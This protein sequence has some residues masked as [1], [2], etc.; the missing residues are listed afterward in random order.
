MLNSTNPL[1]SRIDLCF[2]FFSDSFSFNDVSDRDWITQ[3]NKINSF[4]INGER[5]GF[6]FGK[7]G[8]VCRVYDKT[9]EIKEQS[10]KVYL[11]DLWK[12]QGWNGESTVWRVE[13]EFHTEVLKQIGLR[14]I[15][16][17]IAKQKELWA[18]VTEHWLKLVIP[19]PKDSNRS[20][21]PIHP[22][23][24]EIQQATSQ[25]AS[26]IIKDVPTTKEPIDNTLFI[27]GL[28]YLISF[29]ASRRINDINE[30]ISEYVRQ[31]EVF[32]SHRGQTLGAVVNSKLRERAKRFNIPIEELYDD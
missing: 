10:N 23:W 21:W 18:A 22:A 24:S 16:P 31:A 20:R 13:F 8:V 4:L 17:A 7:Q 19:N 26:P 29:M 6:K 5:S 27:N 12:S 14:S 9:R 25:G 32:Y 11:Y 30:A 3:A 28:G 2:D 1:I 15:E